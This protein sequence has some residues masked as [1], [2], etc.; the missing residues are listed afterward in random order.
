MARKKALRKQQE[1]TLVPRRT[2]N[3]SVLLER[4]RSGDSARAVK[5]YLDAGGTA[6]ALTPH[7]GPTATIQLPLLHHMALSNSHPHKELAESVRLLAAAGAD[8]NAMSGPDGD[9]RTA[10]V[11][12]SQSD[13]CTNVAQVY[14]QSGA[15]ALASKADG[16]TSMHMAAAAGCADNFELLLDSDSS[17]VHVKD[18]TG[19]TAL[20]HVVESESI[21]TVKKLHQHGADLN[22]ANSQKVTPLMVRC[23]HN[24]VDVTVFLLK[25]GADVNAIDYKGSS[26]DINTTNTHDKILLMAAACAGHVHMMEL[27]VQRGLSVTKANRLGLT[28]VMTAAGSGQKA[29]AEWLIQ[30][31][32][33][34]NASKDG[35]TALHYPTMRNSDDAADVVKVLLANGADVYK[36]PS[37][38]TTALHMAASKRH[39]KC[40]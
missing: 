30:H 17:L 27:L 5:A 3:L 11:C 20:M 1:T 16:M 28:P 13:C 8:I 22:T 33:P 10:L 35:Y 7:K 21:N 36:T 25:A 34:V 19:H 26:A 40:V 29:A 38:G 9:E 6:G 14:L 15:D 4:A 39:V 12:A 24:H 18:V 31:G 32:I 37:C 2:S 23:V